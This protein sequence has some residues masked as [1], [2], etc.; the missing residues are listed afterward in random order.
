MIQPQDYIFP[1]IDSKKQSKIDKILQW[2]WAQWWTYWLK[3]KP[4]SFHLF[5]WWI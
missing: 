1:I 5:N 3:S 4:K 2:F